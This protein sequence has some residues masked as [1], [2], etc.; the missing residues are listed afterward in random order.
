MLPSLHSTLEAHAHAATLYLHGTL[1]PHA[2]VGAFRPC[3]T[4]P[5]GVR[6]LRVD[7]RGV[8]GAQHAAA[9]TLAILLR[10]WERTRRGVARID[11]PAP[12]RRAS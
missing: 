9:D 1:L 6:R 7:L 8:A 10:E 5:P 2:V 4:L 11:L 3:Y 12:L